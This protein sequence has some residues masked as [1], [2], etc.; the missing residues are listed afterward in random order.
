MTVGRSV[1]GVLAVVGRDTA[2]ELLSG[3]P[4][5]TPTRL[6]VALRAA[7]DAQLVVVDRESD[8]YRFRHALIGEVVYD[9]L[10][11]PERKRLHRRVA[12]ALS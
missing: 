10:L 1:L 4:T 7:I 12:D 8:A 6:E 2:H 5:S 3:S 11:P 9:E